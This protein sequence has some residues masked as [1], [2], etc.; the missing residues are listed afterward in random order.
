MILK[1]AWPFGLGSY[2][3]VDHDTNDADRVPGDAQ[4]IWSRAAGAD[5]EPSSS[6]IF[7]L[8][9]A[10]RQPPSLWRRAEHQGV[11]QQILSKSE[12][13]TSWKYQ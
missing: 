7:E 8:C 9:Y 11:R 10:E 3:K 6:N 5:P 13:K 2:P 4:G 1:L 12:Q